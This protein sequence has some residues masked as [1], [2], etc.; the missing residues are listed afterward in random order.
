[1][2][3]QKEDPGLLTRVFFG[4]DLLIFISFNSPNLGYEA[5]KESLRNSPEARALPCKRLDGSQ[6]KVGPYT[7]HELRGHW[8]GD[9]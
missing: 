4:L 9:D 7:R 6:N 5:A 2:L 8:A 1:M 3:Y